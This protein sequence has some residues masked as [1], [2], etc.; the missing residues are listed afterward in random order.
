MRS[1]RLGPRA[2]SL[3]AFAGVLILASMLLEGAWL[4]FFSWATRSGR[5]AAWM[6]RRPDKVEVSYAHLSSPWPGMLSFDG[7]EVRGRTPRIR[8]RIRV[9]RG[10]GQIAL[11]ALLRRR[12]EF[13]AVEAHGITVRTWARDVESATHGEPDNGDVTSARHSR[14]VPAPPRRASSRGRWT[15]LFRN[16]RA[17]QISEVT[18]GDL[19]FVGTARGSGGFSINTSDGRSEV[20]ASHLEFA[21][22]SVASRGSN[23]GRDLRGKFDFRVAPW[24]YAEQRGRALLP[25]TSARLAIA[26]TLDDRP[27]LSELLRHAPGISLDAAV[28][29]LHADL[30][31][32]RGRLVAGSR[33][34]VEQPGRR[35]RLL[36]FDIAG[37]GDDLVLE[38]TRGPG[39]ASEADWTATFSD[40]SMSREGESTAL[41][42]G[43]D[44]TFSGH[45]PDPELADLTRHTE[46]RLK[47]EHALFPDL[48]RFDGW[49][50]PTA[51]LR[52]EGGSAAVAGAVT[53][54]LDD[55]S[56][57]GALDATFDRARI[58]WSDLELAGKVEAHLNLAGGDIKDRR[59]DL[60][61]SHVL[62]KDFASPSLASTS[63]NDTRGWWSNVVF[64]QSVVTLGPPF[65]ARGAFHC[66]MRDTSPLIALFEVKH[67]LPGWA[68]RLL[69]VNDV[70]V[71]GR[72]RGLPGRFDLDDLESGV[73]GGSLRG[74]ATFATADRH[75]K[76][77]LSWRR[78]AIG[79]GFQGD[80]KQ[81]Q[82]VGARKWFAA[83]NGKKSP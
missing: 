8:W 40:F 60:S 34:R 29:P 71:R 12:L 9:E 41:L 81:V 2:R 57:H 22:V 48:A 69:H 32:L 54:R 74:R 58:R 20:L 37:H 52:L 18:L 73:Y 33:L 62:L 80:A 78:L 35:I 43:G 83:G 51:H 61:G 77:L 13:R 66:R 15:F 45:A 30:R 27:I 19:S 14:P 17:D 6:N 75:G 39:G 55:L 82:V 21:A 25:L 3:L 7:L 24:R 49:L 79:F 67:D 53:M 76:L 16:V 70:D 63:V 47:I 44:L 1:P 72:F 26:G 23:V 65:T 68:S 5:L 11:P 46:L 4:G 31:V 36:G 50:P 10:R 59:V 64:D 56:L 42:T 28:T 38:V